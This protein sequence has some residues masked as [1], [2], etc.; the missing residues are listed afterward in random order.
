MTDKKKASVCVDA[1][2]EAR[3]RGSTIISQSHEDFKWVVL[4]IAMLAGSMFGAFILEVL[5]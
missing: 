5:R 3:E 4:S 2:A 1:Q